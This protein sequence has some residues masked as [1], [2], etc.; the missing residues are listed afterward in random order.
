VASDD[1]AVSRLDAAISVMVFVTQKWN[2]NFPVNAEACP[3]I[4]LRD[5]CLK[6]QVVGYLSRIVCMI[7]SV[8]HIIIVTTSTAI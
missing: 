5:S 7:Y 2:I 4:A 8:R 1:V 3:Y 6:N